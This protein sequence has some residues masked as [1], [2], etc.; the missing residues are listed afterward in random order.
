M[1]LHGLMSFGDDCMVM[2][3]T[4]MGVRD[5]GRVDYPAEIITIGGESFLDK[6]HGATG[7]R[8]AA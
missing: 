6:A 2:Y 8:T 3:A 7:A 1:I 5:S 4:I